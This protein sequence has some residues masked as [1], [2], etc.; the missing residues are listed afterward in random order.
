VETADTPHLLLMVYEQAI[1]AIQ[2]AVAATHACDF[3][4]KGKELARAQDLICELVAGVNDEAGD[5]AANLKRLYAY[6]LRRLLTSNTTNDTGAMSEVAH[7]LGELL[8]AWRVAVEGPKAEGPTLAPAPKEG[9]LRV[10][11]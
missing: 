5:V 11:L 10:S 8:S 2:T 9:G 1:G 3:T 6:C 4:T 7:I